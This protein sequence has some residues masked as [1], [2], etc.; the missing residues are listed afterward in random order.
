MSFLLGEGEASQI[1]GVVL[2]SLLLYSVLLRYQTTV[3]A[4]FDGWYQRNVHDP[5]SDISVPGILGTLRSAYGDDWRHRSNREI[6]ELLIWRF[7]L[8]QHQTMSYD[9]GFGGS[10]PLFHLDNTTIIGTET[11]YSNL[12][13]LNARS[14][15]AMQILL[16]LGLII[17]DEDQGLRLTSDGESW[18]SE[19][20]EKESSR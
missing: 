18:L 13:A 4:Q 14:P 7:V 12:R 19:L 17:D 2:A 10:S 9:R 15:S 1:S 6:L 16:D 5:F 11:D 20:L 8:M 3:D